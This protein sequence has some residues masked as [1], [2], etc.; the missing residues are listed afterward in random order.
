MLT[1]FPARGGDDEEAVDIVTHGILQTVQN[2]P[3][4]QKIPNQEREE[5]KIF[6]VINTQLGQMRSSRRASNGQRNI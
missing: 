1:F 6:G 5:Q 2:R 3:K 4:K